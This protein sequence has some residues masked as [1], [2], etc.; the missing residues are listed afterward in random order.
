MRRFPFSL[1]KG[2]TASAS[3][4]SYRIF[5][6]ASDAS[7][8]ERFGKTHLVPIAEIGKIKRRRCAIIL[9]A[10]SFTYLR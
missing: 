10:L 8:V 3:D 1:M 7:H 4:L 5:D 6:F 9:Q 2:Y